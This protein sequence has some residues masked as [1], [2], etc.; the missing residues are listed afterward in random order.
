MGG[1]R[2]QAHQWELLCLP[3][4]GVPAPAST[5]P[6]V[7]HT[8]SSPLKALSPTHTLG[9]QHPLWSPLFLRLCQ[10]ARRHPGN[11]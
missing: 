9:Q 10:G 11:V 8:S 7:A 3:G 6:A 4:A 1:Q 5:T 2:P